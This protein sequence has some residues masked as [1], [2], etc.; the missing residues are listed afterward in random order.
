MQDRRLVAYDLAALLLLVVAVATAGFA[1]W[2]FAGLPPLSASL[3]EARDVLFSTA[4]SER[5]ALHG[6]LWVAWLTIGYLGLSLLLGLASAVASRG[7]GSWAGASRSVYEA[8]TVAPLRRAV[9]AVAITAIVAAAWLGS[10]RGADAAG[11]A[12]ADIVP[13]EEPLRPNAGPGAGGAVSQPVSATQ[14]LAYR[15]VPGDTLARIADRF[16]GDAERFEEIW[17]ANEGRLMVAGEVFSS[18]DLIRVGWTIHLPMPERL[19]AGAD[20][21]VR[22]TVERG[23]TLTHLAQQW[24]GDERRWTDLYEINR[25][26]ITDPNVI[27]VGWELRLPLRIVSSAAATAAVPRY[28]DADAAAMVA[29]N[30]AAPV[31]AVPAAAPA[32]AAAAPEPSPVLPG[33][34]SGLAE[35]QSTPLAPVAVVEAG[36]SRWETVGP[37][38]SAVAPS[39]ALPSGGWLGWSGLAVLA[40]GT[41]LLVTR[42]LPAGGWRAIGERVQLRRERVTGSGSPG[43]AVRV[44]LAVRAIERALSELDFA[45]CRVLAA[46]ETGSELQLITRCPGGAVQALVDARGALERRIDCELAIEVSSDSEVLLRVLDCARYDPLLDAQPVRAACVAP[47]GA[48]DDGV[49]YVN[50]AAAGPLLITGPEHEQR[51]M[52]RGLTDTIFATH[53]SDAVALRIDAG[54]VALMGERSWVVRSE[55]VG[56]LAVAGLTEQLRARAGRSGDETLL[57]LLRLA[58][59]DGEDDA[60]SGGDD[61]AAAGAGVEPTAAEELEDLLQAAEA[62][63]AVLVLAPPEDGDGGE[64]LQRRGATTIALRVQTDVG[65]EPSVVVD[66][67]VGSHRWTL[68]QVLVQ[69]SEALRWTANAS[70]LHTDPAAYLGV[71]PDPDPLSYAPAET[72]PVNA[73]ALAGPF[74]AAGPVAGYEA[75]GEDDALSGEPLGAEDPAGYEGF[76]E[77]DALPREPLGAEDPAGYEGFGEDDALPREPLGAEAPAGYEAFGEDDALPRQPLG[78]EA[79]AGYEAFGEDDALPREPLGA[80]APAGY[81]AFGEDDAVEEPDWLARNALEASELLD[82]EDLA[83]GGEGLPGEVSL[84]ATRSGGEDAPGVETVAAEDLPE[85]DV[86][87]GEVSAAGVGPDGDGA[88]PSITD[89]TDEGDG[90]NVA[91][92]AEA[93][94]E[95]FSGGDAGHGGAPR[96]VPAI[97]RGGAQPVRAAANGRSAEVA[98]VAGEAALADSDTGSRETA[99]RVRARAGGSAA[100]ATAEPAPPPG[101]VPALAALSAAPTLSPLP[102]PPLYVVNCMGPLAL[103]CRGLQID[104]STLLTASV[105]LLGLLVVAGPR[106]V[107]R[108]EVASAIWPEDAFKSTI[109]TSISQAC[110]RIRKI[111]RDA[112]GDTPPGFRPLMAERGRIWLTQGVFDTD[113]DRFAAA[114]ARTRDPDRGALDA[115][116]EALLIARREFLEGRFAWADVYRTEHRVQVLAMARRTAQLAEQVGEW[117]RALGFWQAV[118]KRAPEDEDGAAGVTRCQV[119]VIR[120]EQA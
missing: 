111:L 1:L 81:E 23:D 65:A 88:A 32:R 110:S 34:G 116:G 27:G 93:V 73:P 15:V 96:G 92:A 17:G 13:I 5:D 60:D 22:I 55:G 112:A 25:D 105:Q 66:V 18:P 7:D 51:N 35:A 28:E 57:A 94:A 59:P 85:P 71:N 8:F 83:Y 20:G 33:E 74:V 61:V 90:R 84:P 62:A 29:P 101:G 98:A 75:F 38:L 9:G 21:E 118:V 4:Q 12:A 95:S 58:Q 30:P 45:A 64:G 100:A 120:A 43:D 68:D 31:R 80:E 2:R 102:Q 36:G 48:D 97:V 79:P 3:T 53:D 19:D 41:V 69:P 72:R 37:R 67:S 77:D 11:D 47:V 40:A 16:Y 49:L 103:S 107:S 78:A 50:L 119:Q 89:T 39:V 91:A 24:L 87:T 70:A 86:G 46:R 26:V 82:A 76:G 52:L 6:M 99:P 56:P 42:R 115:A 108:E 54:I 106:G 104:L 109:N 113:V 44:T 117:R 14:Q 10:P 63:R 114:L